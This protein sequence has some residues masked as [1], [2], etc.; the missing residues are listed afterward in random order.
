MAMG[1]RHWWLLLALILACMTIGAGWLWL[2]GRRVRYAITEIEVEMT[3][4][5]HATAARRLIQLLAWAP[6]CDQ[7][8]Y[9]LGTCERIRGRNQE[10][11]QAWARVTPG[12][13]FSSRAISE[14]LSLLV[15]TG[16]LAL[17]EQ[18]INEAAEDRR[19]DRNALRILLVPAFT[20]QG[21]LEDAQRLIEERWQHLHETGEEASELAVNLGR[22]SLELHW[23]PPPIEVVRASLDRAATLAPDDDRVWLGQANLAIRTGSLDAAERL[24]DACLKRRPDD[25][26]VWQARLKW[27]IGANRPEAVHQALSHLPGSLSAPAE[28]NRVQAWLAASRGDLA[29]ERQALDQL[30]ATDPADIVALR[31]LAKLALRDGDLMRAAEMERR[32]AA[33][34]RLSERFH[35]LYD[36]NQPIRDAV[37]MG[38]LA[39]KLG[40]MF[41]AKVFLTVAAA[42]SLRREDAKRSLQSLSLRAVRQAETTRESARIANAR[43]STGA[44]DRI[45]AK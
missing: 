4:G 23:T 26:S 9:L 35:H 29:A 34:A 27:A 3:A 6:G 10:A 21:R 31:R 36:R 8:A 25:P 14:R 1:R 15:D 11:E 22:L 20:Q 30:V 42:E 40:H 18:V 5:R 38:Q 24:L 32:Q 39:E 37:E 12:S 43:P 33:I 19:N 45:P 16:R 2:K 41:V 13:S 28:V 17:A 7:A 44:N